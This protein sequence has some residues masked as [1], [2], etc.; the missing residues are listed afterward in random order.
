MSSGSE[1]GLALSVDPPGVTSGITSAFSTKRASLWGAQK[2]TGWRYHRTI[3][4]GVKAQPCKSSRN[5]RVDRM[6]RNEHRDY[7]PLEGAWHRATIER[8]RAALR[9]GKNVLSAALDNLRDK[10]PALAADVAEGKRF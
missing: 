9:S 5:V 7:Q 3:G 4:R 6:L 2:A 8:K 10:Q 1:P